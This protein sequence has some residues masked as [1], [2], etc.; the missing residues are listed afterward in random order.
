M[1]ERF[2]LLEGMD[3]YLPHVDGVI[4][5]M[6]NYCLNA[7]NDIDVLA[8]APAHKNYVDEQPYEI[9][10]CKSMHV[11]VLNIQYG[12]GT[13][14]RRFMKQLLT[15]NF[16]IVHV[17]SPFNMAK[18]VLKVAKKQGIPAV[19]TF[20]TNM[21]PIFRTAVKSKLIA[22]AMVK[23]VGKLYNKFDEV[24]VCS[25]QVAEQCRSFGYTGKITYLPYGTNMPKCQDKTEYVARANAEFGLDENELFFIYV[26]RIEKLKRIDF[27][28]DSLKI[29]KDKGVSFKF[30]AVGIGSE[31]N[32]LKKYAAKLGLEKEVTFT[33]FL[34]G[35]LFPALYA[36]GDLLLFPSLY[37]N[38]GLVKV[39]AAA[40][41]TAGVFIKDSCAGY[42]VTDGFNGYL[43]DDNPQAFAEK[44]QQAVADRTA[45][46][47]VGEQAGKDLYISWAECTRQFVERLQQI[48]EEHKHDNKK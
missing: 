26:G 37:D 48:A 31:L 10:R 22:E 47:G 8:I 36:R 3:S 38:F 7:C 27:I 18:V 12:R 32:N 9:L 44:I 46:R 21:R 20:H 17:N 41:D 2:K 24:F 33:G 34:D 16:D 28:L 25:P 29:L 23:H 15:R 40:Y 43:S 35:A 45:L 11:P 1:S 14:D 30:Y 13:R 42:G 39:E 4:N 5:C 6:H 19:A